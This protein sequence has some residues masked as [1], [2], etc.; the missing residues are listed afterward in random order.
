MAKL[1]NILILL[2]SSTTEA[3]QRISNFTKQHKSLGLNGPIF[4]KISFSSVFVYKM[5]EKRSI[6]I[7]PIGGRAQPDVLVD[8]KFGTRRSKRSQAREITN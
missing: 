4:T 7:G 5:D 8:S 6:L 2:E 3:G 1:S